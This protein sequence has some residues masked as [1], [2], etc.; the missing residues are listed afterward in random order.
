MKYTDRDCPFL[1]NNR[2]GVYTARPWQCRTW[3]FWPENMNSAVWE[4]EVAAYCPGVGKGKLYSAE[5]IEQIIAKKRDVSGCPAEQF[6][7][8]TKE[9]FLKLAAHDQTDDFS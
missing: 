3:P 8:T 6:F 1:K 5:E 9:F 7:D 4:R 2:C